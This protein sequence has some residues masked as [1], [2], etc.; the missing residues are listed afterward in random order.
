MRK[1]G[2]ILHARTPLSVAP[3]RLVVDLR[4]VLDGTSLDVGDI[5][6]AV[7]VH[8]AGECDDA[9]LDQDMDRVIADWV[10]SV[11]RRADHAR[12][13]NGRRP[14]MP[15]RRPP[16]PSKPPPHGRNP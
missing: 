4:D 1:R 13:P 11:D 16:K 2:T 5:F 7:V 3:L 12:T 15:R 9:V 8:D 14:A 10:V 6:I